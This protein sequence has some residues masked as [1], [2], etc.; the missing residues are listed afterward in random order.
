ML[1][2]AFVGIF[3]F[4]P[5]F[6]GK[7]STVEEYASIVVQQVCGA[8]GVLAAAY[9]VKTRMGRKFSMVIPFCVGGVLSFLFFLADG[10]AS[11]IVVSSLLTFAVMM[12]EAALYTIIPESYSTIM[13]NTGNGWAIASA[14]FGGVISPPIVGLIIGYD[15]GLFMALVL[16]AV[17]LGLSGVLSVFLRETRGQLDV[18]QSL[19]DFH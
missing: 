5:Y 18:S 6:L 13:R 12:G 2:F 17:L 11:T 19:I 4:M 16:F 15:W 9:T 10:F 7:I 3:Y 1:A 14:H 8:A